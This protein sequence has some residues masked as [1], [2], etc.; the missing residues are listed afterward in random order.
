MKQQLLILLLLLPFSDSIAQE[1]SSLETQ[2]EDLQRQVESMRHSFDNLDKAIDDV[3]WHQRL[4]DVAFVDEV[5]I[6]GPPPA[7]IKN[8]TGQGARNPVRFRPMCLFPPTLM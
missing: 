8:P 7:I 3:T 4:S 6:T 2:V 5:I 1:K